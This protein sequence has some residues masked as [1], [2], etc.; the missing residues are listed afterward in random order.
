VSSGTLEG[1]PGRTAP[2]RND[3]LDRWSDWLYRHRGETA[4]PFALA[5]VV[6][7]RPTWSRIV[8]GMAIV[9]V[10]ECLRVWAASHIGN[11]ARGRTFRQPTAST[12]AR[13]GPYRLMP[14]PLYAGNLL[15]CAGLLVMAR[16]GEPWFPVVFLLLFCA[17]YSLFIRREEALKR[18]P[19]LTPADPG[20]VP[21]PT[22]PVTSPAAHPVSVTSPAAH[23]ISVAAPAPA[24]VPSHPTF[25]TAPARAVHQFGPAVTPAGFALEWP[26]LRTVLVLVGILAG[27]AWW[28]SER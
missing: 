27:L 15:V 12:L 7:A 1:S 8:G 13:G 5:L 22:A 2:N 19:A 16:A 18:A 24:A 9:V 21:T 26:T 14:H 25:P 6:L 10:G 20:A 23:P 11:H 28:W 4:V 17:Q 3:R